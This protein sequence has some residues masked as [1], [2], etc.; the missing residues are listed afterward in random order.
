MNAPA[1]DREISRRLEFLERRISKIVEETNDRNVISSALAIA[2]LPTFARC[3]CGAPLNSELS[4]VAVNVV[5]QRENGK[6]GASRFQHG[7]NRGR[8][9][10]GT[11]CPD[12]KTVRDHCADVK[13]RERAEGIESFAD[14]RSFRKLTKSQL[15]AVV[16]FL[17]A[18][19]AKENAKKA[20]RRSDERFAA[21]RP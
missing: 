6:N 15:A 7:N 10:R 17:A 8:S 11:A 4:G 1:T 12:E 19:V 2:S 20:T 18:A 3:D 16:A 14:Y 9:R 13:R 21:R 5:A